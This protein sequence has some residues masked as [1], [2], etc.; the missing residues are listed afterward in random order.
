MISATGTIVSSSLV[1][2]VTLQTGQTYSVTCPAYNQEQLATVTDASTTSYP[3]VFGTN[4]AVTA[5]AIIPGQAFYLTFSGT[6]VTMVPVNPVPPPYV[7]T[8]FDMTNGSMSPSFNEVTAQ[9]LDLTGPL[10]QTPGTQNES[11]LLQMADVFTDFIVS[12]IISPVPLAALNTTL[13]AGVAYIQ[14]QRVNPPAFSYTFPPSSDCYVSLSNEGAYTVETVANGGTA[15]AVPA[16]SDLTQIITTSNIIT[17]VSQVLPYFDGVGSFTRG[18]S[19]G[20]EPGA[21]NGNLTGMLANVATE[22]LP[23]S[24]YG[25]AVQVQNGATITMPVSNGNVGEM[26]YFYGEG[27]SWTLVT[28]SGQYIYCPAIGLTSTQGPTSLDMGPNDTMMLMARGDGEF[29]I[30]DGSVLVD[31]ASVFTFQNPVSAPAGTS[32]TEVVNY[33]Q[34]T[35]ASLSP[36][37]DNL[38]V[39]GT[40]NLQGAVTVAGSM[41]IPTATESNQP[42]T[43]GQAQNLFASLNDTFQIQGGSNGQ[44]LFNS[45]VLGY[46]AN[47]TVTF[48]PNFSGSLASCLT[49]PTSAVTMDIYTYVYGSDSGVL[50]GSLSF[51]PSAYTGTFSTSGN[52]VTLGAGQTIFVRAPSSTDPTFAN[53]LISLNVTPSPLANGTVEIAGGANGVPGEGANILGYLA[54][55]TVTFSANFSGSY[56]SCLSPST[57]GSVLEIYTYPAG[58]GT[59]TNVGS[60][61]FAASAYTGTFSTS[62]NAVGLSSGQVLMVQ[63]PAVQDQS[64]GDIVLNLAGG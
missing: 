52:T 38:E 27:G 24:V 20:G 56:A 50:V 29:D 36:T 14:G 61:S 13:P 39:T 26:I 53:V 7:A 63:A 1:I 34:L 17:Q 47:T 21:G 57:S 37:V 5:G 4:G 28:Q 32:G 10:N 40:T 44:P 49:P 31:Q 59:G 62:G 48:S 6:T 9:G 41:T 19:G 22:T 42:V 51:A 3:F 55:S 30:L 15:P 18:S 8:L 46:M 2:D 33:T 25:Q 12:G 64:F 58:G 11:P 35:N 16:G 45:Y 60:I 54:S 43:L 23:D